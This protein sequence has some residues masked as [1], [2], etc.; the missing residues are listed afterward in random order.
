MTTASSSSGSGAL[1]ANDIGTKITLGAGVVF[2]ASIGTHIQ[3]N[4]GALIYLANSYT[5]SGGAAAHI[6]QLAG[7]IVDVDAAITVTL[8]G[9][10]VWSVAGVISEAGGVVNFGSNVTWS[11][12]ASGQRFQTIA[13]GVINTNG[14]GVS[15]LPGSTAGTGAWY[16]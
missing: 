10:P 3:C 14:A 5:I 1:V 7:G 8:T 11:G 12:A 13:G 6:L 4:T 2:A 16:F 15:W 9:T